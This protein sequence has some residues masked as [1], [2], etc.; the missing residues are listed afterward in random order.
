MAL[1][2]SRTVIAVVAI[3]CATFL[4]TFLIATNSRGNRDETEQS[5]GNDPRNGSKRN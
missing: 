5:N 1:I 4:A 2:I 3:F